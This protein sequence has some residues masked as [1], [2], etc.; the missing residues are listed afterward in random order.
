MLRPGH[1]VALSG[2][3]GAGKT[4]L[5]QG[6]ARGLGIAEPVTSPT[7][8][9]VNQFRTA[10]AVTLYHIDCYRF[11]EQGTA[12][13][14]DIGANE[15]LDDEGVCVVE[16]AERIAPLLP[17]ERLWLNLTPADDQARQVTISAVGSQYVG[18]VDRL[19]IWW[20]S[21]GKRV[22]LAPE[23]GRLLSERP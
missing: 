17:A 18:I 13:A 23:P 1:V 19:R 14:M 8:I 4:C 11:A 22:G 7:F 10:Q 6:I 9:I 16:W 5:A 20:H 15:L 21:S 3:L 12:E 2:P